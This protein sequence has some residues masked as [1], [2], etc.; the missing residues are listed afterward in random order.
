MSL[1]LCSLLPLSPLFLLYSLSL[2]LLLPHCALY[3]SDSSHIRLCS[4]H[5]HS[6][7][8]PLTLTVY[9]SQCCSGDREQMHSGNALCSALLLCQSPT[10]AHTQSSL[11][12]HLSLSIALAL[13]PHLSSVG[14]HQSSL[15]P[16]PLL[17][18]CSL[19]FLF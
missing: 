2:S 17:L 8:A 5:M 14:S 19:V 11:S 10:P 13:T 7:T 1:P 15:L 3:K 16:S 12:L 9:Q 18:L 4:S 6:H